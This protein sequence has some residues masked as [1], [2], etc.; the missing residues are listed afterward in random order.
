M[1]S[2]CLSDKV[3]LYPQDLRGHS[4]AA[5]LTLLLCT[6]PEARCLY[7]GGKILKY[8]QVRQRRRE[9]RRDMLWRLPTISGGGQLQLA[10]HQ[11]DA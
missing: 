4:G 1:A 11:L 9:L 3:W 7:G 5:A 6:F 10:A 8:L 2:P